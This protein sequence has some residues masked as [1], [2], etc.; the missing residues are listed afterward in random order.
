[1]RRLAV[2]V[3]DVIFMVPSKRPFGKEAFAAAS[4]GMKMPASREPATSRKFRFSPIGPI[5]AITSR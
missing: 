1:V 4:E 3:L 2:A 5:F